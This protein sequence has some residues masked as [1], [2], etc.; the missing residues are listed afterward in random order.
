MTAPGK[1]LAKDHTRKE[2]WSC[3]QSTSAHLI[4]QYCNA[5]SSWFNQGTKECLKL[6]LYRIW[7]QSGEAYKQKQRE[8]LGPANGEVTATRIE[9]LV[10]PHEN[11]T[12]PDILL[13]IDEDLESISWASK[14]CSNMVA[15]DL[16]GEFPPS[17]CPSDT[18][19]A[20]PTAQ[21]HTDIRHCC[22]LHC[23]D[24][25]ALATT[26]KNYFCPCYVQ[27]LSYLM[28]YHL[29]EVAPPSSEKEEEERTSSWY[30]SLMKNEICENALGY[31]FVWSRIQ[32]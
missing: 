9:L 28:S 13:F 30:H 6:G 20:T 27:K 14:N 17:S 19:S 21:K 11:R 1:Q 24:C 4:S 8:V 29:R 3:P 12:A 2:F 32:L 26:V 16:V 7:I 23:L 10:E 22:L 5:I 18:C 25:K 31:W 15:S